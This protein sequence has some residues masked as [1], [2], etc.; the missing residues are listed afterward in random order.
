MALVGAAYAAEPVEFSVAELA[1]LVDKPVP[2]E[3]KSSVNVNADEKYAKAIDVLSTQGNLRSG[4]YVLQVDILLF[5]RKGVIGCVRVEQTF[6]S[7]NA[8][9]EKQ[10]S[11]NSVQ[12]ELM[13]ATETPDSSGTAGD[14]GGWWVID[15]GGTMVSTSR[16]Y[17]SQGM[18]FYILT[19]DM[20]ASFKEYWAGVQAE[21]EAAGTF[22]MP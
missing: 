6:E 10:A 19:R 11:F 7:H 2:K 5:V 15:K 17:D 22:Y 3:L 18:I 9:V 14:S 12:T 8:T 16:G 13:K 1:A 21:E 20:E 4:E